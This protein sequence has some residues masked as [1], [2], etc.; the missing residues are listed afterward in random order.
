MLAPTSNQQGIIPSAPAHPRRVPAHSSVSLR[1]VEEPVDI[2]RDG[3]RRQHWK[4]RRD[5]DPIPRLASTGS[6]E[7]GD[8]GGMTPDRWFDRSNKRPGAGQRPTFDDGTLRQ[9]ATSSLLANKPRGEP[10]FLLPHTT[11][12]N[13][14]STPNERWMQAQNM[15]YQFPAPIVL[16]STNG[17]SVDDYRSVIDDLTIEN[18][19]LREKLRRYEAQYNSDLEEDRILELKLHRDLPS[20]KKR[21]LEETLQA[22]ISTVDGTP[23]RKRPKFEKTATPAPGPAVLPP[24][25]P[26]PQSQYAVKKSSSSSTSNSRPVDSAYA[27]MSASDPT[28]TSASNRLGSGA[29]PLDVETNQAKAQKVQN[30]LQDI[31]EGLLPKNSHTMTERQ[32]KK[33]VV[34]RLEQLF[35]GKV[36]GTIGDHNQPMQQQAISRAATAEQGINQRWL[37][38]EGNREAQIHSMD[39]AVDGV[40]QLE[41]HD[42]TGSGI[43]SD[44][45][46]RSSPAQRP[47]RP[48]DLDPDRAQDPL[49]NVEY[50]RHLGLS[51]PQLITNDASDADADAPN[52]GWTHLNLLYNMAQLHMIN[53][54]LDFVRSAVAD[55][56]SKLQLS[57]DGREIR[58]R[59]GS[60]GTRLS[61]DS[62]RSRGKVH[63]PSDSDSCEESHAKRRKT[64]NFAVRI[65][66]QGKPGPDH[67]TEPAQSE[68]RP[69]QYKPLFRHRNSDDDLASSDSNT[70]VSYP[71]RS[72]A[73]KS[74]QAN[75][76]DSNSRSA[77]SSKRRREGGPM[78]FYS[79]TK[80]CTDLSGDRGNISTP[81][82]FTSVDKDGF[83]KYAQGVIG[84]P[85]Q[86]PH[87]PLNRTPSGSLIP[88][89]PLEDHSRLSTFLHKPEPEPLFFGNGAAGSELSWDEARPMSSCESTL[90]HFDACGLGGTRPADHFALTVTTRV[91]RVHAGVYKKASKYSATSPGALKYKHSIPRESLEIFRKIEQ[92]HITA[93]LASLNTYSSPPPMSP[94]QREDLPVKTEVLSTILKPL[95]PSEL[96][97]ATTFFSD[98]SSSGEGDSDSD[99]SY[100]GVS[101]LRDEQPMNFQQ[102]MDLG[103][104]ATPRSSNVMDIDEAAEDREESGDEESSGVYEDDD[105]SIDMLI[106]AREADPQLL[107]AQEKEFEED[108]SRRLME[109]LPME[110]SAATVD[111]GCSTADSYSS[112]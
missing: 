99:D 29:R 103:L 13:N 88:Y 70:S 30:F 101:H 78:V 110:G 65:Q 81:R 63:S 25:A 24:T 46:S 2:G 47:T 12:S 26:Q 56:S 59:G 75:L 49:D 73:G 31:P 57:P 79:G 86:K 106:H 102:Q 82:H 51:T 9:C 42:S 36:I 111:G 27:S 93:R 72:G 43:S 64:D 38:T 14:A 96:P 41:S 105:E 35:T 94:Q 80:F 54:T 89:R 39:P 69:F 97:G 90:Q 84:C 6:N 48:L 11:A 18:K 5:N 109:S 21:E 83:S 32:R 95:S 50:I 61:S 55:V 19:K 8:S 100:E 71:P 17:S 4:G 34:K 91:S 40:P 67:Q 77:S 98:T 62:D 22:F 74:W 20:G 92:D 15:D 60:E 58:W 112:W 3:S 87:A 85:T 28:S 44:P 7:T 52:M 108:V 16:R 37:P 1:R 45:S 68:M 33:M 10:P 23:D 76:R 66:P 53:V 104:V 107:A